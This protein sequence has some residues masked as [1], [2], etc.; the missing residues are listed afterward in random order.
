M[1]RL[2]TNTALTPEQ[3]GLVA[4]AAPGKCGN[5]LAFAR[6]LK[7]LSQSDLADALD[8]RQPD[9]SKDERTQKG[10]SLDRAQRYAAFYGV[11]V[12]LL[13]PHPTTAEG[14]VSTMPDEAVG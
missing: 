6:L 10:F 4:K 1:S 9:V 2:P 14:A 8:V 12:D 3:R 13:F 7:G 5:R 11:P